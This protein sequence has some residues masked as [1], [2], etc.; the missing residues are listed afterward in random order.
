MQSTYRCPL[1]QPGLSGVCLNWYFVLS[2]FGLSIFDC[3]CGT[4]VGYTRNTEEISD[5]IYHNTVK[6]R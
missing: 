4:P 2:M 1:I 5:Y 3:I 6:H